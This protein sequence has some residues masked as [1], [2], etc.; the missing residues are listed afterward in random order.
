MLKHDYPLKHRITIKG[1]V[2]VTEDNINEGELDEVNSW[3][4]D[5][6]ELILNN[7]DDISNLKEI[8]ILILEILNDQ[9]FK[10]ITE[11]NILDEISVSEGQINYYQQVDEDNNQPSIKELEDFR[12]GLCNLYAQDISFNIKI[13]DI[14]I[15]YDDLI[16]ILSL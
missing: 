3:N 9:S 4:L 6:E 8:K 13:N 11:D 15:H 10:T 16:T 1:Y 7:L 2:R 5:K 14:D 12:N